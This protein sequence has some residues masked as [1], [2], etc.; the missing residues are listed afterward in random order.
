MRL[1]QGGERDEPFECLEHV[2]I[3]PD[4][5]GVLEAAV[6]HTVPHADQ[7]V[8]RQPFPQEYPEIL[9]RA[10]M[11]ELAVLAPRA[12]GHGLTRPVLG[13]E[14]RRRVE[15]LDLASHVER[16]IA[17]AHD[18]EGELQARGAGIDDDDRVGHGSLTVGQPPRAFP[19]AH[20]PPTP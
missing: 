18:E 1:V 9:D 15:A 20:P 19:A 14:P 7:P 11:A 8:I 5:F 10:V 17:R 3:H 16:E 12:F 4:R 2:V 6:N 13:D